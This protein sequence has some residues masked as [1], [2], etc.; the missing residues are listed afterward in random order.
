MKKKILISSIIILLILVL[1]IFGVREFLKFT[2]VPEVPKGK[3]LIHPSQALGL[4]SGK[5][6]FEVLT[7]KPR[8]PQ[9]VEVE[10]DPLDVEIGKTQIVTVKFKTKANAVTE[11]DLVSGTAITDNKSTDFVLKLKKAEGKEELITTWQGEWERKFPIEKHYQIRIFVKNIKGE[12]KITLSFGSA[13]ANVPPGG[14]YTVSADCTFAYTVDGVDNGNLTIAAGYT[15]TINAGQTVVWNPGKSVFINGAIAINKGTPGGQLK[16]TY[17]WMTDAD[18]DNYSATTTQYYG[19]TADTP[20]TGCSNCRRRNLMATTTATDCLDSGTGAQYVYQNISSLV[21]D[22]D[23]DGY[24]VGTAATQCVGATSAIGGRTYYKDS[25]GNYTWLPS[26]SSTGNDTN[27]SNDCIDT[28]THQCCDATNPTDG[29]RPAKAAGEQGLAVCKRCDGTSIDSVNFANDTPDTEGSNQCTC[30]AC[31][32]A[33]NCKT[34]VTFTYKGASVTYGTVSST[35]TKCWLDRNLGASQVATAYNDSNAYGD[36]FQWGRLDDQHQTRTSGLT[37]TLSSTDVPGHSNF[38]YGMGSPYDWRSPQNNNL[39]QGV[40]GTNNPCPSGW[41]IPTET[42]WNNE[43]L[44]WSTNDY[45]GA[46]AS[47]LKLTAGGYR[48]CSSGSLDDVGSHGYYWSSTVSG[49]Y[50]RYLYFYSTNAYMYILSRAYGFSVRCVK[51]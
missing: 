7:D 2:K 51:D 11:E 22:A 32:G 3:V 16:K 17:L 47:P 49:T 44:S 14:D 39:W 45:N 35:G 37:T 8:D 26:A 46:Y 43:R 9:I 41:R 24:S 28:V 42:E 48:N 38:I 19:G 25:S 13:C 4:A 5:Q 21:T 33:G 15:L 50:A 31:D 34:Q 36:L 18:S 29:N 12:D 20:P 30:I 23:H 6:V 40:S 27:D 10:V 1:A